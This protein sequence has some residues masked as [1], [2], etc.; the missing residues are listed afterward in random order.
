MVALA[1][2]PV[3]GVHVSM[4]SSCI[5]RS[6]APAPHVKPGGSLPCYRPRVHLQQQGPGGQHAA[7]WTCTV[8]LGWGRWGS[9][10]SRPQPCLSQD[11]LGAQACGATEKDSGDKTSWGKQKE[12]SLREDS[13]G[14]VLERK[15]GKA[16]LTCFTDK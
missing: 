2:V 5:I 8:R 13:L 1:V 9:G 7:S 11:P 16:S 12:R 10:E 15:A 3:T 14:L 6:V 4:P